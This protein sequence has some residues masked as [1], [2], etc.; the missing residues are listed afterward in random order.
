HQTMPAP[1]AHGEPCELESAPSPH[2]HEEPRAP[3]KS[4]ASSRVH[5]TAAPLTPAC[6]RAR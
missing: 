3:A 6:P 2:A 4:P 5:P 1:H